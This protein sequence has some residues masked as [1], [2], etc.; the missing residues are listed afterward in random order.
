MLTDYF[1][2]NLPYGMERKAHGWV[3]FNR[4]YL[5]LGVANDIFRKEDKDAVYPV[6]TGLTDTFIMELTG[7]DAS[8]VKRDEKGN[9][10]KFWLYSDSTNPMNQR[11]RDNEFWAVYWQKLQSLSRLQIINI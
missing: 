7:Y 9:I 8:A 11:Q 2:L 3:A 4:E 6:Y 1:R 5:P 10:E